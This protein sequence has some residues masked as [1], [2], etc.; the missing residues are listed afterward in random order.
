MIIPLAKVAATTSKAVELFTTGFILG[1][2]V[3]QVVN[4]TKK[5]IPEYATKNKDKV[6]TIKE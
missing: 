5:E 3:H 6:T 1:C 4:S 2:S